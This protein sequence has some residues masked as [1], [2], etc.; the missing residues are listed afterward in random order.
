MEAVAWRASSETGCKGRRPSFKVVARAANRIGIDNDARIAIGNVLIACW[1]LNSLI[2]DASVSHDDAK[3]HK[4]INRALLQAEHRRSL[5][6]KLCL[7]K[8]GTARI[9]YCWN[10]YSSLPFSCRGEVFKPRHAC[11]AEAF[12]ICHDVRL[13][14]RNEILGAEEPS[15]CH[16][17]LERALRNGAKPTRTNVALFFSEIHL[18]Q[19]KVAPESCTAL[20]HLTISA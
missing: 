4:G 16:L 15:N 14:Y 1:R 20:P 19:S 12:R 13:R 17:V 11:L 3:F 7:G 18:C 9:C 6:K 5:A 8:I 2:V 10:S